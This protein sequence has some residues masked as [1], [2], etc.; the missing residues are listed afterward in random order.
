MQEALVESSLFV[1]YLVV[2]NSLQPCLWLKQ[3]R[4]LYMALIKLHAYT[5]TALI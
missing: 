1:K 5:R 4:Y 3:A 2:M